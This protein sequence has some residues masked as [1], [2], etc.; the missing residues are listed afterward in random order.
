MAM[1]AGPPKRKDA[2][3]EFVRFAAKPENVAQWSVDTGYLP[4]TKAA[5]QTPEL[6]KLFTERPGYTIA[7]EQL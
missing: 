4:S 1:L 6:Q 5:Q 2:A 3:F 7:V